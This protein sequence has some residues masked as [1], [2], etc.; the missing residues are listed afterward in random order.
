VLL[1]H[2]SVPGFA[3]ASNAYIIERRKG[4][5]GGTMA[6]NPR[7]FFDEF[8]LYSSQFVVL[9]ILKRFIKPAAD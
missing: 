3:Y 7:R 2:G 4:Q 6:I 1:S 5:A 8:F 9:L